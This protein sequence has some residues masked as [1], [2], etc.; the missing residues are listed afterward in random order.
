MKP[1]N[2]HKEKEYSFEKSSLKILLVIKTQ[3]SQ[4]FLNEIFLWFEIVHNMNTF[5]QLFKKILI[6]F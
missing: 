3:W 1:K 5:L 2:I 4:N 6:I